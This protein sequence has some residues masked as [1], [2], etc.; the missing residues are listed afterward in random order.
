M[1]QLTRRSFGAMTAAALTTTLTRSLWA[2]EVA[3]HA[4]SNRFYVALVADTHII[5]DF[6]VK[7]SE[8]GVEDN[9]SILVTTPRLTAARDFINS[10]SP[11]IEQVFLLGDYFHNYPSTDYDFYFKNKTRLDNATSIN[12][13]ADTAIS[14]PGDDVRF[15]NVEVNIR[16]YVTPNWNLSAG[17]TF[18]LGRFATPTGV[19]YPKWHQAGIVSTYFLSPRTDVY[20]ETIYQRANQL[21]GT[22][23]QGA[24]ISNFSRASG[25]NQL[26]A[27]VGLRHRF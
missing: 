22:G 23:I 2:R 18:T 9:E 14:L 15:D 3:A 19:R 12:N 21:E 6:Y 5:D 10:L 17:Y 25:A 11:A 4:G 1:T 16:Y 13:V 20:V 24:Q 27:A 26:V 7:G 8:N